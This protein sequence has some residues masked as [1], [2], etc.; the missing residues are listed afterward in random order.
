MPHAPRTRAPRLAYITTVP[1]TQWAFLRGQ[2]RFMAEQGY[3]LHAISSPGPLLAKLAERDGVVTHAVPISR[4]ISPLRDCV[5]LW[6]LYRLLGRLKPD[7]VHVST[8]KAALL[9]ALAGWAARIPVRVFLVRGL[10]SEN[11]RGVWRLAF[12]SLERLTARLCHISIFVSPSLLRFARE[13]R[14]VRDGE[15]V[16]IGSGMSNGLD[17]ARFGVPAASTDGRCEGVERARARLG[18]GNFVIGFVGRLAED[19]GIVDLVRSWEALRQEHPDSRLL[20]VG[21][22]ETEGAVP[23][24]WRQ[25]LEGDERVCI[26]GMVEDVVPYYR[27]MS[28]FVF[29]SHGTEGFPNAPMEAAA[30]GLPVIAT[31]VVG[32]VDAVL[33]GVTGTLVPPRDSAAIAAA[34]RSYI[35]DPLLRDRH[36]AAGRARA[37]QQFRQEV[38]WS[39]LA[40]AYEQ[41]LR[42]KGLPTA[43]RASQSSRAVSA[44]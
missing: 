27:I 23:S 25:R 12:R 31:R 10:T 35:S 36:A 39:G 34:I 43:Q 33:H 8:P 38:I 32:C 4:R 1:T 24:V 41:L 29:P 2:N 5:A 20:L 9:G 14:I 15:G 37:L 13:A 30:A 18:D 19:K 7:I 17:A 6:K 26:T 22:W 16:V 21:P 44:A 28:V 11:S 42:T 40:D 3:E